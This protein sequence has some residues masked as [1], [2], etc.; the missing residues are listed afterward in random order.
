[1]VWWV[2]TV[3]RTVG[4]PACLVPS[5]FGHRLRTNAQLELRSRDKADGHNTADGDG[6]GDDGHDDDAT[7]EDSNSDHDAVGQQIRII[8]RRCITRVF[9]RPVELIRKRW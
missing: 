3:G 7:A 4:L 2:S 8:V 9:P 6:D 5:A 1:M